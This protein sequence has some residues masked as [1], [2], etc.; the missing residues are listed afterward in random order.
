MTKEPHPNPPRLLRTLGFS[1]QAAATALFLVAVVA[2]LGG[3][4]VAFSRLP[5]AAAVLPGALLGF[6]AGSAARFPEETTLRGATHRAIIAL[7]RPSFAGRA[8][9]LVVF[10][11]GGWQIVGELAFAGVTIFTPFIFLTKHCGLPL[12]LLLSVILNAALAGIYVLNLDTGKVSE[13]RLLT[14]MRSSNASREQGA[15]QK[16]Q[17]RAP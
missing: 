8:S 6:A 4:V 13:E 11:R 5:L 9:R 1:V 14:E 7:G 17:E 10:L 16:A 12:G 3:A 2:L 15:A